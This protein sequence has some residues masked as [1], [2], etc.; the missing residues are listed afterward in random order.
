VSVNVY[1]FLERV[2]LHL[3]SIHLPRDRR[4]KR[5]EAKKPNLVT[6]LIARSHIHEDGVLLNPAG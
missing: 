2:Q 5:S 4:R 3:P 1:V 6:I